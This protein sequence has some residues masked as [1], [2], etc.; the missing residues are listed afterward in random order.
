M[1]VLS[2]LALVFAVVFYPVSNAKAVESEGELNFNE[3]QID[4][5]LEIA[6]SDLTQ[7]TVVKDG[8]LTMKYASY[9]EANVSKQAFKRFNE[10]V[11]VVNDYINKGIVVAKGNI[12][13][14]LDTHP[15]V[16]D[17]KSPKVISGEISTKITVKS[18][19]VKMNNSETNKVIKIVAA[20]GAIASFAAALLIT[21]PAAAIVAAAAAVIGAGLGLCNWND[22]GVVLRKVVFWTCLPL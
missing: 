22:R 20:A 12:N 19:Y 3:K 4:L 17:A 6:E 10:F 13:D 18:N 5:A 21:L 8:L 15:D 14:V 16:K 9:K 2:L 11:N 1:I 7:T